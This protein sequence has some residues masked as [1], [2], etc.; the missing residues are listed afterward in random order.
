MS[1]L[2][3]LWPII[4]LICCSSLCC[5]SNKF[6]LAQLTKIKKP[7]VL[8]ITTD[9][10]RADHLPAYGYKGIRT[11]NIDSLAKNGILFRQCATTS[12]LTLPAHCSILTG[13]Y[14]TYHGV[15]INGN[16]ALSAE[17]L[18]LAEAFSSQGYET[19]AFVGAF[20]LDGRWGLNQDSIITMINLI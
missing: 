17:N 14:P 18:T 16:T 5:N 12:P 3:K 10:T 20:V 1:K 19:G 4:I 9:T 11:P 15:R 13:T 7:N 8:L 2:Q 6:T